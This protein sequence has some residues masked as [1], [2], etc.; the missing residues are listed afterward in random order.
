M[1][2]VCGGSNIFMPSCQCILPRAYAKSTWII[3][4]SPSLASPCI[5]ACLRN[6][7][8]SRCQFICIAGVRHFSD[9]IARFYRESYPYPFLGTAGR[10]SENLE[11]SWP[12]GESVCLPSRLE[13]LD[14]SAKP[15]PDVF[16]PLMPRHL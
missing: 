3:L 2:S 7:K 8:T 6:S 13:H 14:K 1:R 5:Y 12:L 15:G 9:A 11:I 4:N 16:L 10:E